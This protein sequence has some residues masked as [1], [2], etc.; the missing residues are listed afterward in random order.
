MYKSLESL[1]G[2]LVCHK[3]NISA[4]SSSFSAACL[5]SCRSIEYSRTS[6]STPLGLNVLQSEE[7]QSVVEKSFP[8]YF[9]TS[10]TGAVLELLFSFNLCSFKFLYSKFD[11]EKCCTGH[12]MWIF[13]GVWVLL[14]A[15]T[16]ITLSY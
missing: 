5:V 7:T 16:D 14:S 10:A 15:P 4:K 6:H 9:L 8:S 12:A 11:F 2:F 3:S 1:R 13:W